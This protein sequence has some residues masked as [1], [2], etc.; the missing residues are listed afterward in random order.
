V[1]VC[2]QCAA[3]TIG[4]CKLARPVICAVGPAALDRQNHS[5]R[6]PA[7]V[8]AAEGVVW[9]GFEDAWSAGLPMQSRCQVSCSV[10]LC[11]CCQHASASAGTARAWLAAAFE[12]LVRCL[13]AIS[14]SSRLCALCAGLCCRT[15]HS[16]ASTLQ[17]S[18]LVGCSEP[19]Q[20]PPA[21][22]SRQRP[23]HASDT[24]Y[25]GRLNLQAQQRG[26]KVSTAVQLAK[27]WLTM[28]PCSRV[29][30]LGGHVNM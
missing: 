29:A 11:C 2:V 6:G 19:Q 27:Q 28:V 10:L 16:V 15:G 5:Q 23:P 20:L 30:P 22:D 7:H 9:A 4:C 3:L 12:L 14:T 8:T 24:H 21:P 18:S 25:Q 17:E 1:C 26:R 13:I